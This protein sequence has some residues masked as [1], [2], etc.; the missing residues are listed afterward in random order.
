MAEAE[1]DKPACVARRREAPC[2]TRRR[3]D[4]VQLESLL[5]GEADPNDTYLEINAGAGG[6]ES[7]DW[8]EMLARMYLRWAEA[9]R[10]Q[11][12]S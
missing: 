10:L 1:G 12:R 7:Q 3:S 4:K 9:A 11:G 5:S 8:A 2:R 6:T